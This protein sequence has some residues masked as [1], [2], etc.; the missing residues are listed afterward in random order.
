MVCDHIQ[1]EVNNKTETIKKP[2]TTETLTTCAVR[3]S[4]FCP[5]LSAKKPSR[6]VSKG[7][8]GGEPR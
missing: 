1:G 8:G 6:P 3:G 2:Q 5:H 7:G 4:S